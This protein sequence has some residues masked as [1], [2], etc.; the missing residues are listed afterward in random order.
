LRYQLLFEGLLV[1]SFAIEVPGRL[2][3]RGVRAKAARFLAARALS[4]LIQVAVRY[5]LRHRLV[6]VQQPSRAPSD[7]T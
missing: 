1:T 4:N 6:K 5:Q 2:S 3:V 7:A